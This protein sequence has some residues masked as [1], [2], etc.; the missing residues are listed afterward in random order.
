MAAFGSRPGAAAGA[1]GIL[2]A[3][4]MLAARMVLRADEAMVYVLGHPVGWA[5]AFHRRSGL[6]CPTCGLTRSVVLSLH[7]DL[8]RAWR[9]APA[10]PVI[11]LGLVALAVALLWLC[12]VQAAGAAKLETRARSAIRYGSLA[13]VAATA[14]LWICG[15]A[16]SFTAALRAL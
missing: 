2:I 10:G 4:E 12:C 6:P 1:A 5:C 3:V 15:W 13:Y 7:G 11:L 9:M 14:A 16:V 8:S